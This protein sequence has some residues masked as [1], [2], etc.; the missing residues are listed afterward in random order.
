MLFKENFRKFSLYFNTNNEYFEKSKSNIDDY[1][2]E[3]EKFIDES[4]LY[5]ILDKN[6]IPVLEK[7][8]KGNYEYLIS[9]TISYALAHL[10]RFLRRENKT[11]YKK[12]MNS[13]NFLI[14]NSF[15]TKKTALLK[16]YN[17][18]SKL[19]DGT[20]SAM[21]NGMAISL[22]SRV[23]LINK[24]E[25]LLNF[26]SKLAYAYEIPIEKGGFTRIMDE[27]CLWFD[28]FPLS[29][30]RI[31]NGK[32]F[33]ILGLI[34]YIKI[35]NNK[36]I[37]KILY[38]GKNGLITMLKLFD[39]EWWSNYYIGKFNYIASAKYHSL[40]I[41]LLDIVGKH[42]KS[43]TIQN[44]AQKFDDYNS[45]YNRIRSGFVLIFGKFKMKILK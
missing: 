24:D 36:E 6:L 43:G 5:D 32:L 40:H 20:S 18:Q 11:S 26:C 30:N 28:E 17:P 31:L 25:K 9:L 16:A 12:V 39:R 27:E 10:Q 29:K 38:R 23:Y 4:V 14:S 22:I 1:D 42:L 7:D 37:D 13:I 8:T 45:N 2:I 35:D 44:Y 3:F 21:D 34:D 15:Q 41:L 33:S 19:F